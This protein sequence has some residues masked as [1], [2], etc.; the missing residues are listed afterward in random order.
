MRQQQTALAAACRGGHATCVDMLIKKR[1]DV[2]QPLPGGGGWYPLWTAAK[3]GHIG[4]VQQ[5]LNDGAR[6]NQA[7]AEGESPLFMAC[8][9]GHPQVVSVL[10]AA[11]AAVSQKSNDGATPLF[12]AM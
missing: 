2:N 10:I 12:M 4:I 9:Y 3:L 5:L 11:K 1:A 7:A 8:E 6:I